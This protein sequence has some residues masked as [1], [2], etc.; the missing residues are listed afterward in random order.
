MSSKLIELE[1]I[2]NLRQKLKIYDVCCTNVY[3]ITKNT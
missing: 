2:N 3:V 1:E